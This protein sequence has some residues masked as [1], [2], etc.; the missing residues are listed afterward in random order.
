MKIQ[1]SDRESLKTAMNLLLEMDIAIKAMK[2][3]YDEKSKMEIAL[4]EITLPQEITIDAVICNLGRI[5]GISQLI[6]V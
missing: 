5:D 4:L 2:T 1:I 6:P 3:C